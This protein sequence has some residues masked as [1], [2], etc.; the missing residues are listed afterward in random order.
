MAH[1]RAYRGRTEVRRVYGSGTFTEGWAVYA[2]QLAAEHGFRSDLSPELGAA[3][4]M[5]QLKMQLRMIINAILDVRFHTGDLPEGEA[6]RLMMDRGFQEE[7]E[8][9]GK[10]KRASLTSAQLTTYF[11]GFTQMMSLRRRFEAQPGFSER[12]YHDR[13]LSFGS[14]SPR[15]LSGLLAAP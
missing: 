1:S 2:E 4:R 5:Q 3:L 12:S 14:P 13:L 6:M 7:G 8:A 10:W 11:Y 15:H 9:V